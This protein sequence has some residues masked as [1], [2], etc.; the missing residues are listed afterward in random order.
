MTTRRASAAANQQP[1]DC[2]IQEM[3]EKNVSNLFPAGEEDNSKFC[4]FILG[5]DKKKKREK[6]FSKN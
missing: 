4:C 1:S 2:C 3:N 5:L 6:K